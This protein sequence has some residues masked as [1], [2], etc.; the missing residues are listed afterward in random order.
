MSQVHFL[1][2]TKRRGTCTCTRSVSNSYQMKF[3]ELI[4]HFVWCL[5][6]TVANS[7]CSGKWRLVFWISLASLTGKRPKLISD[8]P[9]H[10][11]RIRH[12]LGCGELGVSFPWVGGR[13][14]DLQSPLSF[15]C[16][17]TDMIIHYLSSLFACGG[18]FCWSCFYHKI[19]QGN[20]CNC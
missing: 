13:A 2:T 8:N 14:A 3:W 16:S 4:V 12:H 10:Y 11:C 15:I 18:K 20:N 5:A 6:Q 7:I 19:Q 9:I 17:N 1:V